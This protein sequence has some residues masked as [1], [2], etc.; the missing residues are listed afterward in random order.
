MLQST[1]HVHYNDHIVTV[2]M[3][4]HFVATS[5][6]DVYNVECPQYMCTE[7]A[8]KSRYKLYINKLLCTPIQNV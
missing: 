7:S 8:V 6:I 1:L 2:H 3:H 5:C 4:V